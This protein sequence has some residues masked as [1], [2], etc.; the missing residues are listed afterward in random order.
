MQLESSGRLSKRI[1][2]AI[3]LCLVLP[4]VV[5]CTTKGSQP[6]ANGTTDSAVQTLKIALNVEPTALDPARVQDLYTSELLMNCFEGLVRVDKNN[7]I[8]P[9]LAERWELSPD[10]KTY[11]FHLRKNALFHNGRLLKA[12]DVKYSW[13]RAIAPQTASPVAANYLEGVVGLKESV[14]GKSPDL[15]GIKVVDDLT[16]S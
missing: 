14:S 8:E 11:T 13:E 15:T 10:G 2:G 6:P 12:A 4:I 7:A 16:L 3:A 1:A 9:A 5:G